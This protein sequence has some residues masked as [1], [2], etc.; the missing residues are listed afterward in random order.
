MTGIVVAGMHRSGTSL[1][2]RMLADGG[3]HPGNEL[4]ARPTEDYFEDASFVA[5]HRQWLAAAV[6]PGKGHQDWGVSERGVVDLTTLDSQ[7]RSLQAS[8]ASGFVVRRSVE[9]DRWV[10]KDPRASLF[11]PVWADMD[12]VRFV[13][14]YR[15]PWDVVDSALRLGA[16]VFCRRPGL[17]RDAWLDY[18]ARIVAFASRHRDRCMVVAAEVLTLEPT[19]VWQALDQ[20]VGMD[21][22]APTGLVD[23][24]KFVRRDDDHAIAALYLNLYPDHMA[25]LDELDAIADLP[26]LAPGSSHTATWSPPAVPGTGGS[27]P[28]GTGVQVVIACHN[29]GD[30]LAEAIASVDQ[31]AHG[32]TELTVVDDGST[33]VETLRVMD[34][35][36]YSGRHVISTPGVGVSAARNLGAATSASCVVLPLDA[37]NRLCA[38]LLDAVGIIEHGD[39]DIVHGQWRRFGMESCIVTPRDLTL[40]GLMPLNSV[41]ACALIRRELLERLG[42]W[43]PQLPFWEDWDLWIGAV[44]VGARTLRLDEVTFDYLVRPASLNSRAMTNTR[45]GKR[46]ITYM[47]AKHP[48]LPRPTV[49][50]RILGILARSSER[51]GWSRFPAVVKRIT[52]RQRTGGE[53]H[54]ERS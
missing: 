16:E 21:G 34:A 54:G 2:A 10:A 35:L 32:A 33:D 19:R 22:A 31:Y 24:T 17:V 45:A 26:R 20:W 11:L 9:Q 47:L 36:R 46:V 4:L 6:P 5:L 43:D 15:N 27:L 29:D 28:A 50:S 44:E 14:V 8:S 37:D 12:E 30:F 7:F 51:T 41:D 49:R 53:R 42:G 48:C 3:Y 23:P 40:D 52:R 25:V 18:N 39:V 1:M 38:P 13:F